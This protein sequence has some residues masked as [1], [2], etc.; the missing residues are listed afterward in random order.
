M[1]KRLATKGVG[2]QLRLGNLNNGNSTSYQAISEGKVAALKLASDTAEATH[3]DSPGGAKEHVM[4]LIDNGSPTWQGNLLHDNVQVALQ[5]ARDAGTLCDFQL[6]CPTSTA[7]TYIFS[8]V[9][10]GF[11]IGLD[12]KSLN[13]LSLTLR[14]S[15]QVVPS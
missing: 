10:V 9:V 12:I 13:A 5:A 2:H 14:I 6:Y 15:G 4:V 1:A 11:D 7:K 3:T 8:A